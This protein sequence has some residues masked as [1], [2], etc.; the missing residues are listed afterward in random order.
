MAD[1]LDLARAEV[2]RLKALAGTPVGA[3]PQP[4]PVSGSPW[5]P[6]CLAER[7]FCI[8]AARFYPLLDH[9]VLTPAGTGVLLQIFADRV[10]VHLKGEPRTREFRPEEIA[11]AADVKQAREAKPC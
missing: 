7:K 1:Y 8:P 4:S 10:Q 5:H 6:E 3:E 11:V 9:E 2:R